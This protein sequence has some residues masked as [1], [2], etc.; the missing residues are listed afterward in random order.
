MRAMLSSALR[1][2]VARSLYSM[3]TVLGLDVGVEIG[4]IHVL[5]AR[6]EKLRDDRAE[7]VFVAAREMSRGGGVDDAIRSRMVPLSQKLHDFVGAQ[8][9]DEDVL[10]PDFIANLDIRS[11]E[12]A[13]RQRAIQRPHRLLD[14]WCGHGE[15][16]RPNGRTLDFKLDRIHSAS[17]PPFLPGFLGSDFGLFREKGPA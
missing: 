13:D 6:T 14:C 4:E 11:I 3:S 16:F 15:P 8:T 9:E 1:F 5:I 10:R 2:Q 12:S 7:D 17:L